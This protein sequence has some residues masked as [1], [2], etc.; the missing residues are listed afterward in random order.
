MHI[1]SFA[2]QKGG[3]GKTTACCN[4]AGI[5]AQKKKR[6]LLIDGDPQCS[7]TTCFVDP[8]QPAEETVA[9]LYE[10]APNPDAKIIISTRIP[11]LD[12]VPGG[13]SLAGTMFD[14]PS[15]ERAG[16]RLKNFIEKYPAY[17][18]VLIDNPPDIG[19]FTINAFMASSWVV[20]PVQPERLAVTGVSQ[21]AQKLEMFSGEN[22]KLKMMGV[23][24]SMFQE[25]FKGQKEWH[26]TI[27]ELFPSNFL[28]VIHRAAAIGHA[29]DTGQLLCEVKAAQTQRP[30]RELLGLTNTIMTITEA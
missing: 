15:Y 23:F 3:V 13:F 8:T 30:Y 6:T 5:L 1:I 18:Y 16:L 12:L 26:Q 7:A 25:A 28:G 24:T 27:K 17:D 9:A 2:N 11:C 21:L 10:K 20:V 14:I 19:I 4:I 29:W 22:P